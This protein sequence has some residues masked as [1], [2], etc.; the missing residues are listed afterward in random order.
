LAIIALRLT[1][2]GC[3]FQPNVVREQYNNVPHRSARFRTAA[4]PFAA[5]GQNVP[6]MAFVHLTPGC[7]SALAPHQLRHKASHPAPL[8]RRSMIA[9]YARTLP[10]G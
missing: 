6:A 5:S 10:S 9:N 3:H 1:V 8:Q 7:P 2:S 4:S